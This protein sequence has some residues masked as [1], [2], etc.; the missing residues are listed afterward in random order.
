MKVHL[1][2]RDQLDA[3]NNYIGEV[4]LTDFDGAIEAEENLGS[5]RFK[6]IKAKFHILFRAGTGIKAGWGIEAGTGIEAGAGIEAGWGID[7]SA[8]I[9]AGWGIKAGSGIEAGAG[10]KA[11]A[12]IEAGSGIEAGA[13]I[14]AGAGI[15]AGIGIE[16]GLS[17]TGEWI[18][19]GLRI[20]AG[21]CLWRTPEQEEM[22]IKCGELRKGTVAF[23]E[24]VITAPKKKPLIASCDGKVVV[25]EGVEYKLMKQESEG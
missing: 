17:I 21:I 13:G 22:Q 9:K 4:D 3:D 10:I 6:S 25:I 1:I 7:A 23:G 16:A 2:T 14:K 11:G 8:G 5:V 18:S 12:G 19:G 20:F 24:L 15:E